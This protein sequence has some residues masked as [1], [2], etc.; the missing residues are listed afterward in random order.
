MSFELTISV[1][2]DPNEA[3]ALDAPSAGATFTAIAANGTFDAAA[4]RDVVRAVMEAYRS[5]AQSILVHLDDV[6]ASEDA[7]FETLGADL[8]SL[9]G[10]GVHVQVVVRE[11]A[12]HA[13]LATVAQ[14]RDWL[15][16]FS[17]T[18]KGGARRALH[19]DGPTQAG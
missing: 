3:S 15:V 14:S 8:M 6:E 17:P 9:R 11:E 13:R 5:G 1:R 18:P 10:D 2:R 12:L 19:L 7:S 16:A 4:E